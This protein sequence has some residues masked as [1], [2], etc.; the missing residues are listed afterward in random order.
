MSHSEEKEI[1]KDHIS[2]D[3]DGGNSSSLC[4]AESKTQSLLP[5]KPGSEEKKH[6]ST[7][8]NGALVARATAHVY[9]AIVASQTQGGMKDFLEEKC[10]LF[11]DL[12]GASI[13][14]TW[15]SMNVSHLL[16]A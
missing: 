8:E 9:R 2:D 3:K 16:L 5:P 12:S 14:K 13:L 11:K 4:K 15:M 7:T 10:A 1:K 6:W